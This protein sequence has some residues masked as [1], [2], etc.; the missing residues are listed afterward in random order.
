MKKFFDFHTKDQQLDEGSID[1]IQYC[2][3]KNKEKEAE[4]VPFLSFPITNR[5]N[6]KCI[7]CGQGGE[8]TASSQST[9]SL[10]FIKKTVPVGLNCGVK[11]FRVTGGEPF[12]HDGIQD[13]LHYFSELGYFTLVNTNGSLIMKNREFLS[14]LNKNIK[15]AVSLDTLQSE[16]LKQISS[17]SCLEEILAGIKFLSD[18]K[19]LLRVNMVVNK[20]NHD[21]VLNVI[22][23]CNE[24]SCDLKLLDVVSVPVPFG[25]RDDFYQEIDTLEAVLLEKCDGIYSHEYT[26]GFGTPC[27]KYKFNNTFVTVKNSVKG[28]HYDREKDGL[29]EECIYYPCH[30][31]LYD[32]FALS[33]GRICGCRWSEKQESSDPEEQINYL[34]GVF[35][36]SRYFAANNRKKM[37]ERADLKNKKYLTGVNL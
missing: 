19:L 29:C 4:W 28:S 24:M 20:L 31:G 13:I 2:E 30:E 11:K 9:I 10:D 35:K 25:D 21:E 37:K 15:F 12:L 26:R 14:K 17:Q 34:I 23:F 27:L 33:D 5:C 1:Y 22:N 8:A 18:E 6:F 16:K 7:Y 32:L 36:H 3:S